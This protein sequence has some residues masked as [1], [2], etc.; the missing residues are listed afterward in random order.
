[1]NKLILPLLILFIP[2]IG[3]SQS[4]I[5]SLEEY[6]SGKGVIFNKEY[7][8]LLEIKDLK[9]AYTPTIDD[10]KKVETIFLNKYN[11][12]RGKQNLTKVNNPKKH[13]CK[14]NRQ[15]LGYIDS[16]GDTIV[17]VN[18]LNFKNKS[19]AKKNFENWESEFIVAFGKYYEKNKFLFKV[20]LN[21][22]TLNLKW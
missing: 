19:K 17:I 21:K 2:L 6:Y 3:F 11:S 14:Y 12:E 18:M 7:M 5:I 13:F 22:S 8:S 10:V 16:N 15:Y 4:K 9:K 1:M 20:N